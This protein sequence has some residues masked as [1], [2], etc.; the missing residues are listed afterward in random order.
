MAA[1]APLQIRIQS[2]GGLSDSDIERMVQE[3][4]QFATADAERKTKGECPL[5]HLTARQHP[6]L[7]FE[8]TSFCTCH[9]PHAAPRSS[10]LALCYSRDAQRG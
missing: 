2:S 3:A 10:L 6:R 8:L 5:P 1:R 9:D 4:E 7:T